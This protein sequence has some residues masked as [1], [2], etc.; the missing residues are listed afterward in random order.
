[1]KIGGREIHG[2]NYE[3]VVIPRTDGNINFKISAV[4]NLHDEF[5]K[6]SPVPIP[7]KKSLPGGRSAPDFTDE[8]YRAEVEQRGKAKYAFLAIKSLEPSNI[9]WDTVKLEDPST[10]VNWETDFKN[11]GFTHSEIQF[12]TSGIATANN[13][14]QQKIDDARESFLL[15][16]QAEQMLLSSNPEGQPNTPSGDAANGSASVRQE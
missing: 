9:E 8:G 14:D 3:Y 7:P 12:I 11:A 4:L 15:T 6:V 5:D 1:M 10:Y 16:L 13:L 2:P